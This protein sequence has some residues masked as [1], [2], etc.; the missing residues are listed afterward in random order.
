MDKRVD[1][2]ADILVNY[3]IKVKP[4]DWVV[5]RGDVIALP[6]TNGT[7]TPRT[8]RKLVVLVNALLRDDRKWSEKPT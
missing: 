3:S 5:L 7:T 1:K 6:L 4:G 8:I 2:L